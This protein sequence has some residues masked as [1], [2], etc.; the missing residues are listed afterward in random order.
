MWSKTHSGG[1]LDSQIAI[2]T[3]AQPGLVTRFVGP[4]KSELEAL[5]SLKK[6]P[7]T[8]VLCARFHFSR[9]SSDLIFPLFNPF[10]EKLC[11]AFFDD[12]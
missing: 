7:Q 1:C 12:E 10:R 4:L 6:M 2:S 11:D 5:L 9:E 3:Q 8:V